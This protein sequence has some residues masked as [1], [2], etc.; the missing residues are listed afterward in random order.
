MPLRRRF[1]VGDVR[2][3]GVDRLAKQPLGDFVGTGRH[4]RHGTSTD[5]R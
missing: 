5:S 3:D 1:V 4:G 2:L